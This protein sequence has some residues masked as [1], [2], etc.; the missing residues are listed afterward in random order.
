MNEKAFG[1]VQ[2]VVTGDW[3]QLPPVQPFQYCI[4]CGHEMKVPRTSAVIKYCNEHGIVQN[5]NK[6]AF[7]SLAWKECN[8]I[9]KN[10]TEI[11][12]QNDL[13]FVAI[14]NKYRIG[15]HLT[16]EEQQLLL[17]HP[18][19]TKDAVRLF[20]TREEV[21]D[22]ND[23]EFARLP[24]PVQRYACLD[25]F[26]WREKHGDLQYKGQPNKDRSETLQALKDHRYQ[27]VV[28][29]KKDMVV[30]LLANLSIPDGLV[31]GSQGIIV[32]FEEHNPKNL[33]D[34]LGDYGKYR[35]HLIDDFIRKRAVKRWPIVRFHSGRERTI[36]AECMVSELGDEKPYCL[37]S[38]TQIP[39]MAGWAMTVHKAQGMTLDRVIVDLERSFSEGLEYVALSRAR[40]L[41]GLKVENLGIRRGGAN[42][43]VL[44]FLRGQDW[45]T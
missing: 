21:K 4:E 44:D 20:P 3:C 6:W 19:D 40:N 32:G 7:R 9:H 26:E 14:L 42:K 13:T 25:N 28:D 38:R 15:E 45:I 24:H 5:V 1:G 27:A 31:N 10:L 23:K 17:D 22:V 34:R 12:R 29:L 41:E 8:F 35:K 11:H 33:P 36:Y 37:L 43:E 16:P 18:S 30:V 2:L 39:L